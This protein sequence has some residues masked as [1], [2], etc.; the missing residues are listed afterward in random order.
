MKICIPTDES[1]ARASEAPV[2]GHFGSAPRFIIHDTESGSYEVIDN[3]GVEHEH[4]K[5]NPFQSLQ[6]HSVDALVTGGIGFRAL[7]LFNE[8]NIKVYRASQERTAAEVVASFK[9]GSLAEITPQDACGHNG[10]HGC[11]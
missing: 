1:T 9:S 3:S 6:S 5:C 10:G 11:H 2:Y 8:Q 7:M 4:G